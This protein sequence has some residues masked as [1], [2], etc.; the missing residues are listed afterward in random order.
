MLR[1]AVGLWAAVMALCAS[2]FV[3][4]LLVVTGPAAADP[5]TTATT[6]PTTTASTAPY[7]PVVTPNTIAPTTVPVT[8]PAAVA[9]TGAD[10]ALMATV[11]AIAVGV[12]GTIVLV[13]RRRRS[14]P[15]EGQ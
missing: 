13:S 1:K 8:K 6:A 15:A 5:T 12:G 3:G 10:I 4:A 7:A 2:M 11:G 14:E 9:F